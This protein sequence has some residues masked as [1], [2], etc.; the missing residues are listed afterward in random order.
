MCFYCHKSGNKNLQHFVFATVDEAYDHWKLRHSNE[1]VGQ[2]PFRFYSLDLL[3]C[4]VDSCSYPYRRTFQGLHRHHQEK[5]SNDLFV[6]IYNGR[7]GMCLYTGDDLHEHAC[8]LLLN[9][10]QLNLYNPILLTD[11]ELMELLAIDSQ[12]SKENRTNQIECQH[13]DCI[14][15]SK[16][17]VIKHYQQKHGYEN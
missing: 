15:E 10:M 16:Q 4:S 9:A 14:F 11:E 8:D 17:E 3:R 12:K 6:P 13:C 2:K 5:H 1:D 7:C